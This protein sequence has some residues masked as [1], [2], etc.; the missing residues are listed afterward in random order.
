MSAHAADYGKE[1]L[2][3]FLRYVCIPQIMGPVLLSIRNSKELDQE[4]INICQ[5]LRTLDPENE[6]AYEQEIRDITHKLVINEGLKTI[7]NSKIHVNTEG[8]KS[9]ISNNLKTVF[10][11]YMYYRNLKLDVFLDTINS[12]EDGGMVQIDFLF[13]TPQMF[14]E[15]V[16]TIRN[17]FVSGGEYGL[18][19]Y[20]S[21]NIRHGTLSDQLRAPLAKVGLLAP[22]Q[23]ET[24]TCEV[25]RRWL[26]KVRNGSDR[27]KLKAA[28]I[29]FNRE[30]EG[31]IEYVRKTLIQ[32]STEEK[33]TDGIFDY[34]WD[35]SNLKTLQTFL[36]ENCEFDDF[37]DQVFE[38]LWTITE[39]NLE[40]MKEVIRNEIKQK[41]IDAF[42]R[43]QAVVRNIHEQAPLPEALRWISEAQNE[44]D[45]ALEKVCNW[46]KR[47]AESRH[48]DFDLDLAFQI[49]FKMIQNIHPEKKFEVRKLQKEL[50][51]Q[52][53]GIYL[54]NYWYIFYTLFDNV[55]KYAL[56]ENG[57]ISIS[58]S[59][60]A[61]S[62]GVLIEMT[63]V[64]DCANGVEAE[65]AK[66]QTALALISDKTYLARAKQEGGSGI[67]K[68]YKLMS[69]D[70]DKKASIDYAFSKEKNQFTIRI[71]GR[72]K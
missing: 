71:E 61:D 34:S 53:A 19:G 23:V 49:G 22:Y 24:G 14:E 13:D 65:E 10:N 15:I 7:E 45:G 8:I 18:D 27:E 20:L 28:I 46:F 42:A 37:I 36:T 47:S 51:E 59:L 44:M 35:D 41:Y 2:I 58:C 31:I 67:P 4:R 55:S 17:E 9:R 62:Q 6:E 48:A 66:I 11:N 38:Y 21:M 56:E 30:T 57:V 12:L 60:K 50:D 33:P 3:F 54:K 26:A 72:N 43:L 5:F 39:R 63:N 40:K 70:L 52:I 64:Y 32:I 29:A 1:E 25:S 69:V 16:N 68:I